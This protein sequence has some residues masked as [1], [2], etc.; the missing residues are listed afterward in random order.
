M[1][2]CHVTIV[3]VRVLPCQPYNQLKARSL[4]GVK[5]ILQDKYVT[6]YTYFKN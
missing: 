4:H 1:K 6:L 5:N 2:E 3:S